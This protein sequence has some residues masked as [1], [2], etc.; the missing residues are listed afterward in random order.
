MTRLRSTRRQSTRRV[1]AREEIRRPG[2]GAPELGRAG[3]IGA[4]LDDHLA[5]G[6]ASPATAW[7]RET[8]QRH[9]G[10]R[11]PR[12]TVAQACG[13]EPNEGPLLD[14]IEAKFAAIYR[15]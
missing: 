6:D 7:L 9:G 2:P 14:Y 8:V 15:L 12:E 11:T 4:D 5:R 3:A 10:L 13:F 1:G